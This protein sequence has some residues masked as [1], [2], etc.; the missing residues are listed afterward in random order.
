MSHIDPD[1]LLRYRFDPTLLDDPEAVASHVRSCGMCATALEVIDEQERALHDGETWSAAAA[2]RS[3]NGRFL[4]ASERHTRME[5]ENAV[6]RRLLEPL[7]QP[8][9]RLAEANL[10]AKPAFL[11]A[12]T[13]RVLCETARAFH[14]R[15]P[16]SALEMA[17][18]AYEVAQ[19]LPDD[20]STPRRLSM[21]Y[22]QRERANALRYLG[23]VRDAL[24][25]LDEAEVLLD[26]DP[27]GDLF[28]IAIINLIRATVLVD[29]DR[30][31]EA[32]T[33]IAK[34]RQVFREYGDTSRELSA[35]I[36]E[37]WCCMELG[38]VALAAQL[39]ESVAVTARKRGDLLML[40][41]GVLNAGVAYRH[42][43]DWMKAELCYFE[44]LPL[45]EELD[46]P[47]E[48]ARTNLQI[49]TLTAI[50]GDLQSAV[51]LLNA[52]TNELAR[53]GLTNDAAVAKLRWAETSLALGMTEGVAQAC[54]RI[55]VTFQSEDL[56]RKARIALAFL[57]ETLQKGNATHATAQ[58]VREYIEALPRHPDQPFV[59]A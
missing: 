55:I 52:S 33:I 57:H 2:M 7:L 36:V 3:R 35:A 37:A 34:A 43:G 18:V 47:S 24:Q 6:A 32:A 48:V 51:A 13:V 12:G 1:D 11:N 16:I 54:R 25:A 30:F 49:A 50:R 28:D 9:L 41:R 59:P 27:I 17:T 45:F 31:P 29:A 46:L 26:Q 42:M 39:Y 22:A 23:R 38:Y 53:V 21:A 15:K 8:S 40:A 5:R 14:E 56:N 20:A 19:R 44:A 58:R 4:K 10:S